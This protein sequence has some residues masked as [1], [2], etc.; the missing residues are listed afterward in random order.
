MK[1]FKLCFYFCLQYAFFITIP[2]Y[3]FDLSFLKI[4]LEVFSGL[5]QCKVYLLFFIISKQNGCLF[6]ISYFPISIFPF[7]TSICPCNLRHIHYPC[8][9]QCKRSL[10]HKTTIHIIHK[11]DQKWLQTRQEDGS[12]SVTSRRT[13][14]VLKEEEIKLVSKNVLR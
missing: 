12:S 14:Q 13:I 8:L 9:S 11:M 7:L 5:L 6:P 3:V 1:N 4:I 2:F 10:K